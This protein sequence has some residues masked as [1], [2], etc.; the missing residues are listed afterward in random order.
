MGATLPPNMGRS[1]Q[2]NMNLGYKIVNRP[3]WWPKPTR[4]RLLPGQ[5]LYMVAGEA[6]RI[7]HP[8][9]L[10]AEEIDRLYG[11]MALSADE[12]ERLQSLLA[13]R[14]SILSRRLPEPQSLP[15]LP[16]VAADPTSALSEPLA[17][18]AMDS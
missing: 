18:E 14:N 1:A 2:S 11:K 15:I 3:S 12:L 4:K 10:A 6:I 7:G 8:L 16:G 17:A 5:S 9:D 13:T